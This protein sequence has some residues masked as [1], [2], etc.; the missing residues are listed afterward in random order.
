[1][2]FEPF[3][4]KQLA[5]LWQHYPDVAVGYEE[6]I[7]QIEEENQVTRTSSDILNTHF[8]KLAI[9]RYQPQL[10]F[11]IPLA[12]KNMEKMSAAYW[13]VVKKYPIILSNDR[14]NENRSI[15]DWMMR[16]EPRDVRTFGYTTIFDQFDFSQGI[17]DANVVD[18]S[19][20]GSGFLTTCKPVK[21]FLR[22]RWPKVF[23]Y[24]FARKKNANTKKAS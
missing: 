20:A 24:E 1:M 5:D 3:M 16:K 17:I 13:K 21:E 14:L 18:L 8:Q 19:A 22:Q 11:Y 9:E 10:N 23:E 2:A 4:K 15:P 7:R 6:L 12:R